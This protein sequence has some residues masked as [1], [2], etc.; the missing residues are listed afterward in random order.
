ML[1]EELKRLFDSMN[2]YKGGNGGD[3]QAYLEMYDCGPISSGRVKVEANYYIEQT[4]LSIFGT[5]QPEKLKELWGDGTDSDGMYSRFLYV[6]QKN[7]RFE[8]E[9]E[10]KDFD[11]PIVKN[12]S[13]F[14]FWAKSLKPFNYNLSE[15]AFRRFALFANH[16]NHLG[17]TCPISF[18]Q[19]AYHKSI[20]HCGRLALNLHIM[21]AYNGTLISAVPEVVEEHTIYKA[22]DLVK[23]FLGQTEYLYKDLCDQEGLSPILKSIL[24]LSKQLGWI[25]AR[26]VKM[27]R[28]KLRNVDPEIIRQSFLDLKDMA[29]GEVRGSGSRLQFCLGDNNDNS[30]DNSN[31]TTFNS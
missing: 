16:M 22:I 6:F 4:C 3:E 1:S 28:R 15:A 13:D 20:G 7:N 27:N 21:N 30:F 14:Y 5:T 24:E 26:E 17:S 10:D 23:F 31:S 18:L 19:H 25:S 11:S 2:A 9:L 8:W 12:L 29:K